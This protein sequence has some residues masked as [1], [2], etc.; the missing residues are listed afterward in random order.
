MLQD[1]TVERLR[2]H[3]EEGED[4]SFGTG[5]EFTMLAMSCVRREEGE[6]ARA[7]RNSAAGTTRAGEGCA[8]GGCAGG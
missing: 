3:K 1:I 2:F 5:K 8:G 4:G 7:A 6:A